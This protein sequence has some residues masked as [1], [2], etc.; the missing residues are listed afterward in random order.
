MLNQELIAGKA[1]A[2]DCLCFFVFDRFVLFL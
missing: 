2:K 1:C